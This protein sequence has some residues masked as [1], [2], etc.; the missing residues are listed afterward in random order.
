MP[1]C[2]GGGSELALPWEG[3]GCDVPLSTHPGPNWQGWRHGR[4]VTF[5]APMRC[6]GSPA[7]FMVQFAPDLNLPSPTCDT[8]SSLPACWAARPVRAVFCKGLGRHMGSDVPG[9]SYPPDPYALA[10]PPAPAVR[11]SSG[12]AVV[13]LGGLVGPLGSSAWT[14]G[15]EGVGSESAAP[16]AWVHPARCPAVLVRSGGSVEPGR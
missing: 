5:C 3:V 4:R 6:C 15:V 1:C 10:S 9:G 7:A 12:V 8:A 16:A 13:C 14:A 11:P 2:G